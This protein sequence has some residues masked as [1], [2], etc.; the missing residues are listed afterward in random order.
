M[1]TVT[2]CDRGAPGATTTALFLSAA[3]GGPATI[4]APAVSISPGPGWRA[5]TQSRGLR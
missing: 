3:S 2:C 1:L 4:P 5:M